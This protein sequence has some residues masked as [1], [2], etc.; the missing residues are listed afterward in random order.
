M[1]EMPT[2]HQDPTT[3]GNCPMTMSGRQIPQP[4]RIAVEQLAVI[5]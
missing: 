2:E 1:V 3:N 4:E 5:E